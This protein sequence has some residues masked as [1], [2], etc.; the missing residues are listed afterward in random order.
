MNKQEK[1]LT[2]SSESINEPFLEWQYKFNEKEER[3]EFESLKMSDG[4]PVEEKKIRKA[5]TRATGA[6]DLNTGE[7]ILKKVASGMSS[8]NIATRLNSAS[9]LL[10]A[11]G[12]RSETEALLL[13]QFLALQDS[14]IKCLELANLPKQ[15]FEYR[16]R[17]FGLANKLLNT[18]NQTMLTVLKYRSGGQQTMQVIHVH[19]EGQAIVAQNVSSTPKEGRKEK[20][21]LN[22]MDH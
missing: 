19:N 21:E 20:H 13:G 18:A 11:L 9:A 22:P 15:G 8:E 1:T 2:I 17:L 12:P 14:G 5:L 6:S 3:Y 4:A 7:M 10:S 16:E